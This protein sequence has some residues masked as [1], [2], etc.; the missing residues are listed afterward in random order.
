MRCKLSLICLA[1]SAGISGS[2]LAADDL[3]DIYK[4][5]F[6]KDPVIL[7]AQ[8]NRNAAFEAIDEATAALLPQIDV[9]GSLSYTRTGD[10]AGTG[11][12]A[13][14]KAASA[15]INL[16]QAI[17]RHSS[18]V[19][20]TIA[21]KT[22][23]MQDLTYNDALQS[24]IIRVATAYFNT[25]NAEDNLTFAKAYQEALRLQLNEA[26]RR[27]QVGLIA[28]TDQLQAQADYDLSS[29]Q[30]IVAENNLINSYEELRKLTGRITKDLAQLDAKRFSTVPVSETPDVLLKNAEQ[31]NLA[32][33]AAIVSRDIAKDSITLAQTGHEPTLDLV[34]SLNT[35][36]TDYSHEIPQS[37]QVDGN[38]HE[39][40]IG[41]SLNIP[42]F[43]GG[44]TSSQVAQAEQRYIAAS[45]ALESQYRNVVANINNGY[46]NVSAAISS[47]RAYEQLEKSAASS[48]KS[49]KAG[50][51]V[52]TR[53]ISDVLDATQVLYSA[54][55][56]LSAARY[57]YIMSRLNLL[58]AQGTLTIQDIEAIN[59]GLNK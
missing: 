27:F 59:K 35:T 33:Q 55:E 2:A 37:Q 51:E 47:V 6:V 58:Y 11:T 44:A 32:L 56:N 5:A 28:E 1:V 24:L 48:L 36:Y 4:E 9:V 29:A 14:N 52:G 49:V 18:W 22:A 21:E 41:L 53:T 34:G 26:T 16:S 10:M 31:N 57:N 12:N 20:R 54:K 39:G 46:N 3:M 30:V 43:H 19:N 13:N 42:V 8:A 50:Y 17:W 7:Q 23:A 40:T 38:T 25:L 15:G 45:E